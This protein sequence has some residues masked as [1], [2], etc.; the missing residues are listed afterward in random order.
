M[1]M[2]PALI[3]SGNVGQAATTAAKSE[4]VTAGSEAQGKRKRSLD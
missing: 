4:G 2:M 1:A 3:G